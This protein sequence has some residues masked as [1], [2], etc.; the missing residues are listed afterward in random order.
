[1]DMPKPNENH[2]RLERLV[3]KWKGGE[4]LHPS[5][6]D[7]NGGPAE[8]VVENQRALDGFAVIQNYEQRRNGA[9][10]YRGHGVMF[11]DD[12]RKGYAMHWWDSMGYPPNVFDGKFEGDVLTFTFAGKNGHHRIVMELNGAD[13]Y[14]FQ[15]DNSRDGSQWTTFMSA[16]YQ[17]QS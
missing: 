1:M 13:S 12:M 5:P 2:R 6:W 7:P 9:V 16:K 4:Q 3:G 8:G 11:W 14:S 10:T 15:M 17:R